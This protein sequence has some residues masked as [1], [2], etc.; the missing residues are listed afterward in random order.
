MPLS[1]ILKICPRQNLHLLVSLLA[2]LSG[3]A[4]YTAYD[5]INRFVQSDSYE[6]TSITQTNVL[7]Q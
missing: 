7:Q 3:V 1:R 5:I 2:P 4:L 6:V